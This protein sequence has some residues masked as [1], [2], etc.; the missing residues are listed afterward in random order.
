MNNSN[1]FNDCLN[2]FFLFKQRMTDQHRQNAFSLPT[3]SPPFD[4]TIFF[5]QKR[6]EYL[7][8]TI[9]SFRFPSF[10]LESN[11][12]DKEH[13]RV[14][15]DGVEVGTVT[16]GGPSP[17]TSANIALALVGTE[18]TKRGTEL[19]VEVRGRKQKA[20]VVKTPF[21]PHRYKK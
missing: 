4:N 15:C 18:Y 11:L 5:H 8:H 9:V 12:H 6:P 16:S 1:L 14:Y 19:E 10:S 2:S 13:A 17:T 20:V 21:F 3:I 7:S